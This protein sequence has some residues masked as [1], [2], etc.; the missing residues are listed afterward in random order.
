MAL[1][2]S[3]INILY[4]GKT[5][6]NHVALSL[7]FH[8]AYIHLTCSL[9]SVSVFT[10]PFCIILSV[11]HLVMTI[12]HASDALNGQ[13]L[14]CNF[15]NGLRSQPNIWDIDVMGTFF[16]P[17]GIVLCFMNGSCLVIV[18]KADTSLVGCLRVGLNP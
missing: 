14:H 9:P 11:L 3:K 10:H 6:R 4:G 12:S 13:E 1:I 7:V 16:K 18:M 15:G 2:R 8:H 17:I 5:G